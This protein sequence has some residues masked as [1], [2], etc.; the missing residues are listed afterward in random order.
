MPGRE[1]GRGKIKIHTIDSVSRS[2]VLGV[3]K[4]QHKA[5]PTEP[6]ICVNKEDILIKSSKTLDIFGL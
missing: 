4:F 5:S 6:P 1:S 3:V 2:E